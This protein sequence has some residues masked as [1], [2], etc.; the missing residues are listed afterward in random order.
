MADWNSIRE[1]WRLTGP[2]WNLVGLVFGYLTVIELADPA[3]AGATRWRCRCV[4]GTE[5]ITHQ[6]YLRSGKQKSCGCTHVSVKYPP[7]KAGDVCGKFTVIRQVTVDSYGA[8]F[9]CRCVCGALRVI[10]AFQIK[11]KTRISCGC[12]T[13]SKKH[14]MSNTAVFKRWSGMMRRCYG[15][16]TKDYK[17]YGGR[18]ITV[19][20]RWH[21]FENFYAD[22]GELPDPSLTLERVNNEAGYSKENCIWAT[23]SQQNRNK[24]PRTV[25]P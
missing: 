23:W 4:C 14:G 10:P 20:E 9:E 12:A 3:P 21:E 2:R 8:Y 17:N 7:V 15:A 11:S 24:R 25:K 22:M 5:T 19:C 13:R 1:P 6:K 16:N 18:G